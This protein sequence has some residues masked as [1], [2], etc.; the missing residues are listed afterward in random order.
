MRGKHGRIPRR[1]RRHRIIPA[2]AGQT[3]RARQ[4][5][6]HVTDHP[7]A[8]GANP[9]TIRGRR[10]PGGS[11]PRMRGKRRASSAPTPR[12]RIIPAHA[13]QTESAEA[14]LS[15]NTDHP[16]ACG[17][18]EGGVR[19]SIALSGSSPR[20]RGKPSISQRIYSRNRIIPAHAGQTASS[21]F[22]E[23]PSSDHPRACGANLLELILDFIAAGSSPRMRGKHIFRAV[24]VNQRR[25]IPAHAGQTIPLLLNCVVHADHPR[26]CGANSRSGNP[27]RYAAGSSPR[28]RGK[29]GNVPEKCFLFR[30]I[31]AH[32]GQTV[33]G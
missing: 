4:I 6:G 8:C 18:N 25:I 1:H 9:E 30:I 3:V 21:T 24:A 12:G 33:V 19:S 10:R 20:M 27:H 26:A 17:A 13:G 7:R 32:A 5:V 14:R 15:W 11:S 31:P 22:C 23:V 16:R 28:M 29:L 2:H